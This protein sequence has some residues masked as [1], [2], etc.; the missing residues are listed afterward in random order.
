M[1]NLE[2]I[3]TRLSY[4]DLPETWQ[5]PDV[6]RF[7]DEK[8][9][10]DYQSDAL[11]NAARALYLYY[12][13]KHDWQ[14][15]EAPSV[16]EFRKSHLLW[17]YESVSIASVKQ[18]DT[19]A[20]QRNYR[21]NPAFQI[22]AEHM[23]SVGD[24]I[25]S[26]DLINRMGFWMATGSGKTLVMVKLIEYLHYLQ[27]HGEVPP[28]NMLILAP[29][30]HLLQQIKRTVDEFN[31]SGTAIELVHLRDLNRPRPMLM[32]DVVTVYY[33]RS[34]NIA[35]VQKDA[36]TDY[37][38]YEN[39]GKW[40]IFLD[41]AHKGG[42]EDSKRQAYYAVM[43]R[44]GFL[45]NFSATFVD[46]ADIATTVK[47][48]NLA[49]FIRQG[50]G[51][52]IYV[53]KSEYDAFKIR[54]YEV[55]HRERQLIVLKS[56]LTLACASASAKQLR[57]ETG[58]AHAYHL[59]MMLT[60][61]NTVNTE[62][63]EKNDLWSFFQTLRQVA[64]ADVDEALFRDAKKEL[65]S[66]WDGGRHLFS[67]DDK[68]QMDSALVEKM[69]V[70]GL[71]A[72]IFHSRRRGELEFVR[73]KD[74]KELALQLKNADAP[75]AVIRIG[76]ISKWRNE[77][78]AGYN[79]TQAI[80]DKSFFETLDQNR[81]TILMGSRAFFESWDSNRPNVINF[82]NIGSREA[83]KFVVQAVGRGVRIEPLPSV[84]KRLA[85]MPDDFNPEAKAALKNCADLARPLETLFLFATNRAAMKAVLEGIQ[86]EGEAVF[87]PLDGFERAAVPVVNAAEMPLYVPHYKE[88]DDDAKRPRF[89]V[90]DATLQRFK[91][92]CAATSDSVFALRDGL[93]L[94]QIEAL[95]NVDAHVTVKPGKSYAKLSFMQ[96]RLLSHIAQTVKVSDGV[97]GLDDEKDIIHFRKIRARSEYV[98]D[99]KRKVE[100]VKHKPLSA[101]EKRQLAMDFAEQKID[102]A[103]FQKRMAGSDEEIFKDVTIR[104]LAGH[105]YLPVVLGSEKADYIQHIIKVESEI[106]FLN[107]LQEWLSGNP[108]VWDGWMFSKLDESLDRIHIPYF[109]EAKNFAREFLPDFVFWMCK[110]RQYR[111]VFVDPKG[112]EHADAYRK[113]DGYK[114]L[115]VENGS[116]RV[117][118]HENWEVAVDLYMYNPAASPL[119]AYQ[120]RWISEPSRIFAEG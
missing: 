55:Q 62:E 120:D 109:D 13:Q 75:F 100:A 45:F 53:N 69:T 39:D 118:R 98:D 85:H 112:A 110:G 68:L 43:A 72:E 92:W 25:N 71:R 49:E 21:V 78:L 31:R 18:F 108:P 51:K 95:R 46:K 77:F 74:R 33:H 19:R 119:E 73:S 6:E 28:H 41:E 65:L 91:A 84:R 107:R 70:A 47:K 80:G 76:D 96:T 103:E 104:K 87:E 63:G 106:T 44:N 42:K 86:S 35:D 15:G 36:L 7:S 22:L 37:R 11:R 12:E 115:F 99:L 40:F 24:E 61:V 83:K 8:S 79:E 9:L 66:D 17:L 101:D 58:L 3:T 48:F 90:D 32:G 93:A 114:A 88:E 54:G 117:F 59:P 81:V 20:D 57:E 38:A 111:I 56:L 14:A 5:I 26:R 64:S 10:Y 30:E 52:N 89:T 97:R 116:P 67:K 27:R 23:E 113:I 1:L 102:E 82:I 29:S 105:Y 50:Y 2:R 4:G 94:P 60:L 34:D 16:N